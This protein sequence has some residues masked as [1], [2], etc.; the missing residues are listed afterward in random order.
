MA[1]QPAHIAAAIAAQAALQALLIDDPQALLDET[2]AAE[3]RVMNAMSMLTDEETSTVL[4]AI[5]NA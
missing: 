3:T 1:A 5:R 2:F 4:D